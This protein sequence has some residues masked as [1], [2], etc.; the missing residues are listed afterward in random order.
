MDSDQNLC[1]SSMNVISFFTVC[2]N[3]EVCERQFTLFFVILSGNLEHFYVLSH[4]IAEIMGNGFER[5]LT[6]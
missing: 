6:I 5:E 4:E 1:E 3:C 2:V